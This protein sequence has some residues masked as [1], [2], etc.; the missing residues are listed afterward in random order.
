MKFFGELLIFVLLFITNFRVFFVKSEKRDPLVSFA[1][2]SLI[3]SIIQIFAWG[4]DLFTFL[5]LAISLLVLICN[6][7]GMIRYKES[8]FIDHYSVLMKIWAVITCC[9]SLGAFICLFI[10]STPG[11]NT[12]KLNVVEENKKYA[13]SFKS[14]FEKSGAFSGVSIELNH[15]YYD[16]SD[17]ADK[18]T[19]EK[20]K[21]SD[22]ENTAET[23]VANVENS[24]SSKNN[25]VLFIPD[26][27]GDTENYKPYLQLLAAEGYNV[28]SADFYTKDVSWFSKFCDMKFLRRYCMVRN[29]I[30]EPEYFEKQL[31][32]FSYNIS[33]E[34]EILMSIY[35]HTNVT[36]MSCL[37]LSANQ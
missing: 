22:K 6:I 25:I 21:K 34:C 33:L 20:N 4:V 26:K 13:G 8:L 24:D 36:A 11:V 9:L 2:F 23:K 14:G 37:H 35:Q 12:K 27:R 19:S 3:L 30:K 10:F 18:R 1:P 16:D 32:K 28:Y 7:H 5:G 29:F 17:V 15:F 31:E